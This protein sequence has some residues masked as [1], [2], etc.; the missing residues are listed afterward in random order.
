MG[1]E[2]A[3]VP[4][5]HSRT[6]AGPA[7]FT[8][9]SIETTA[10]HDAYTVRPFIS[11]CK[12]EEAK[13]GKVFSA[14]S[15]SASLLDTVDLPRRTP[16]ISTGRAGERYDCESFFGSSFFSSFFFSS[17]F[18]RLKMKRVSCVS[19]L[20]PIALGRLDSGSPAMATHNLNVSP[21]SS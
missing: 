16:F 13:N 2:P 17:F 19:S 21:S 15:W 6:K 3:L 1:V 20:Y 8:P 4:Y 9:A 5:V 10:R 7:D 18:A 11:S 12:T 14:M